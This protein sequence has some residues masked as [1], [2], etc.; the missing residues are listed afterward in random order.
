MT[1]VRLRADLAR[2]RLSLAALAAVAVACG[3]D[4][5]PPPK[6]VTVTRPAGSWQGRG[7]STL[8]FNSDSGRLRITWQARR[9]SAR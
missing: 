7:N 9:E 1:G 4:P 2:S 5:S 8:G 6:V 3:R